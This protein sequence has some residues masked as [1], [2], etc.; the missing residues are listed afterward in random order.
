MAV[1]AQQSTDQRQ[2]VDSEFIDHF[3]CPD[4]YGGFMLTPT[5]V[6]QNLRYEG[7]LTPESNNA[8]RQA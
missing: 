5:D 6:V 7:Y 3:R 1:V 8:L 4:Q 2:F